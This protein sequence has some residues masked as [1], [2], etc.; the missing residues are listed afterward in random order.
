MSP[1]GKEPDCKKVSVC[2]LE[3]SKE[4]SAWQMPFQKTVFSLE[5]VKLEI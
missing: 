3:S 1:E 4:D 5:V 2:M